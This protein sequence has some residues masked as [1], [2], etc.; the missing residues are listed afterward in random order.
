MCPCPVPH[1]HPWGVCR[2]VGPACSRLGCQFLSS[3]HVDSQVCQSVQSSPVPS[4]VANLEDSLTA[5]LHF[6]HCDDSTALPAALIDHPPSPIGLPPPLFPL[7]LLCLC[8]PLSLYLSSSCAPPT[9]PPLQEQET[10]LSS[11]SLPPPPSPSRVSPVPVSLETQSVSRS[12]TST[13]WSRLATGPVTKRTY[14]HACTSTST[15]APTVYA[16]S[17][18]ST[19]H[20]PRSLS[21]FLVLRPPPDYEIEF[22]GL[23]EKP[24]AFLPACLVAAP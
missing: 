12:S 13:P 16:S 10:I 4:R 1:G 22:A 9:P 24:Q 17:Y 2:W 6:S 23:C 5:A 11:S 15:H 19:T 20:P 3:V 7:L 18:T 14:M 8:L 21:I